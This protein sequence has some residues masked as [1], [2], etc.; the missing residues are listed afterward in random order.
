ME[1]RIQH[2]QTLCKE[3]NSKQINPDINTFREESNKRENEKRFKEYLRNI[4][5]K[6]PHRFRH[7]TFED[8]L[9]VTKEQIRV[10]TITERFVLSFKE[11]IEIG[12]NLCFLGKNGT[13]KTLLS[14]IIYQELAKKG[15]QVNYE[16]T[17]DFIRKLIDVRYKSE[18]LFQSEIKNYYT[19]EFLIL[20]E[21]TESMNRMGTPSEMEKQFLFRLINERYQR[22]NCTLL[23]SN[24]DQKE[25]T[26]LLGV[27]TMD[28]L[29]ENS[30]FL[31]FNWNSFRQE[32]TIL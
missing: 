12:S 22:K 1:A 24:R 27:P 18:S 3:R 28:R 11:R 16:P 21:V 8:Y 2:L 31:A 6:L 4:I 30:V 14:L 23:I 10:K 9:T 5:E 13:G 17:I 29:Y 7:K 26:Q 19:T 15:F 20:D 25:L 32:K